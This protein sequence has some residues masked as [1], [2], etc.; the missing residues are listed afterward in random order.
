MEIDCFLFG[1]L[2]YARSCIRPAFT[3]VNA[4][5][6]QRPASRCSGT[7]LAAGFLPFRVTSFDFVYSVVCSLASYFVSWCLWFWGL[8]LPRSP[9]ILYVYSIPRRELYFL[10]C[11][12]LLIGR[13]YARLSRSAD[14]GKH[15][16]LGRDPL[17]TKITR[18][19]C[20][21]Q[22]CSRTA[23]LLSPPHLRPTRHDAGKMFPHA[24]CVVVYLF[25]GCRSALWCLYCNH[26]ESLL[27]T[28]MCHVM[29]TNIRSSVRP[30]ACHII[31]HEMARTKNSCTLDGEGHV[32][33]NADSD[34]S[35]WV[36]PL[37]L[38]LRYCV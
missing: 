17:V 3:P 13:I 11:Q 24:A 22:R 4:S 6:G 23:A 27:K 33:G 12:I 32:T 5:M 35:F 20:R 29:Q 16:R 9:C 31:F 38:R 15:Q 2:Y 30:S 18:D 8:P 34:S 25:L 37:D 1:Y 19:L 7:C 10:I 26:G 36:R 28:A 14:V 21:N